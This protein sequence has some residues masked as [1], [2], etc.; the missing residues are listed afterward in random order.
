MGAGGA[1]VRRHPRAGRDG[2]LLVEP[3]ERCVAAGNGNCDTENRCPN[4]GE[5]C[6]NGVCTDE[7]KAWVSGPYKPCSV[8]SDCTGYQAPAFCEGGLCNVYYC[9]TDSRL[10]KGKTCETGCN[11]NYDCLK[12]NRS[13][14]VNAAW[15]WCNPRTH[16]CELDSHQPCTITCDAAGDWVPEECHQSA[17]VSSL[18]RLCL[19]DIGLLPLYCEPGD[20]EPG[21]CN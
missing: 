10:T 9:P 2:G 12:A 3:V 1:L 19:P 14:D 15:Q 6:R 21:H 8:D 11:T 5:Q 17:T 18:P 4:E 16:Q 20:T 13:C 7:T